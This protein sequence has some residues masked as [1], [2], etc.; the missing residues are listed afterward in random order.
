[1]NKRPHWT[2]KIYF[3]IYLAFA[4]G[5]VI[6]FFMPGSRVQLYYQ[7]EIGFDIF[8]LVPFCL[9]AAAVIF[10]ALSVLPF[11]LYISRINFLSQRFWQWIFYLRF[12]CNICGRPYDFVT[13]KALYHQD[14]QAV[15]YFLSTT[16]FLVAPSY[17]A[18]GFYAFH[19][20]D[21]PHA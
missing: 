1:M 16:F 3:L 19:K 14:I 20:R 21:K 7:I 2:W 15:I 10:D 8:F 5:S 17:L 18:T 11:F 9:N 6:Y 12:A 4:S 13:L